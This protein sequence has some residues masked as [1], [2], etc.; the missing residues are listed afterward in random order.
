[1]ARPVIFIA[2]SMLIIG[3]LPMPYGYYSFLRLVAFLFFIWASVVS[4]KS[5]QELLPW[6]FAFLA[7]IFNPFLVLHL[8]KVI[9]AFIDLASAFFIL[10][11]RKK[12]ENFT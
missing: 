6:A 9:W 3:V 5:Q 2:A 7:I 11:N 1:V 12:L 4:Y 8:N 10:Y